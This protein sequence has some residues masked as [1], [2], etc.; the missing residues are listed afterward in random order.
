MTLLFLVVLP[1]LLSVSNPGTHCDRHTW[2]Y[3]GIDGDCWSSLV[4]IKVPLSAYDITGI[5]FNCLI[6]LL[7]VLSVIAAYK[8]MK[9]IIYVAGCL[10]ILAS[11]VL[12]AYT[13]ILGGLYAANRDVPQSSH[14]SSEVH[15]Q[16]KSSLFDYRE[17]NR[18]VIGAWENTMKEDCCCGVDG[19]GDFPDI[20]VTIPE[21]C[22]CKGHSEKNPFDR[23][24]CST[25]RTRE[26]HMDS[27]Y[28]VT[29][30]GCLG[31]IMDQVQDYQKVVHVVKMIT[32]MSVST[33]Q[34]ILIILAMMSTSCCLYV[35]TKCDSTNSGSR[36][37]LIPL[38]EPEDAK[39]DVLIDAA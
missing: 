36:D 23:P 2:G 28:N 4:N 21:R 31:H 8:R 27:T 1:V 12:M 26:C 29:T 18:A 7:S 6:I 15:R 30:R 37:S 16:L 33:L 39:D 14:I 22:A 19:F 25:D 9:I 35:P 24:Y 38:L 5:T 20:G 11:L 32:F 17:G 13:G 10:I 34:L 3:F